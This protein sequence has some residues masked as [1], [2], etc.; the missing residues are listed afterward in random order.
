MASHSHSRFFKQSDPKEQDF[1]Y[2]LP[3]T[4]W[5]RPYEYAWCASFIESSDIILDAA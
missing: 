5:S 1:V 3:E 2:P 4:W